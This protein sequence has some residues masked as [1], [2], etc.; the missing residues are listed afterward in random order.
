VRDHPGLPNLRARGDTGE[1]RS[2]YQTAARLGDWDLSFVQRVPRAY[3]LRAQVLE[4]HP[5][6][7]TVEPHTLMLVLGRTAWVWRGVVLTQGEDFIEVEL[8]A[9]PEVEPVTG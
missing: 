9:R 5:Y 7:R 2:G 4:W 3:R 6:W 8:S 1:V